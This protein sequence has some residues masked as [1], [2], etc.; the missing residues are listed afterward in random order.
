MLDTS[1]QDV[2]NRNTTALSLDPFF[3]VVRIKERD[4][5]DD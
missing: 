5:R 3:F 2:V 1:R 4:S